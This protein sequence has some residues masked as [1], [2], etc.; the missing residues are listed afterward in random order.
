MSSIGQQTLY[1]NNLGLVFSGGGARGSYQVGVWRALKE[2]GITKYVTYVS[3]TSVGAINGASFVQNELD[4]TTELWNN[5]S[6]SKVF[7][8]LSD[9]ISG[10][11]RRR[12]YYSILRSL[13]Q[14]RGLNVDPLKELLRSSLDENKIRRS[15]L[16]F[17][18]V[19]FDLT[20]RKPRF[21]TKDDIPQGQLIDYVIASATFPVFEPH[22]IDDVKYLD[23]GIYDNRP[24]SLLSATSEVDH[25]LCIDVTIARYLWP[26]KGR[27]KKLRITYLRPSRLLGSPM[28]FRRDKIRRNMA[29]GYDDTMKRLNSLNLP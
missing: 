4:L 26:N 29:L 12:E 21:L 27:R 24:L 5:L 13:V 1:Q 11:L 23:G 3:G 10:R 14:N 6:Y 18:L 19:V 17:G 25:I 22:A 15:S 2:L 9:H 28:A 16:G 8:S 7:S 20:N